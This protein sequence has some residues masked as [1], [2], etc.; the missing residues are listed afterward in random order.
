MTLNSDDSSTYPNT[1]YSFNLAAAAAL[2][3]NDTTMYLRRERGEVYSTTE[4]DDA[5]IMAYER[6]GVIQVKG[7]VDAATIEA[8]HDAIALRR[9]A[10]VLER[11][12]TAKKKSLGMDQKGNQPDSHFNLM[13][14]NGGWMDRCHLCWNHYSELKQCSPGTCSGTTLASWIS[15]EAL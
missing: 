7:L 13:G 15:Q 2:E 10:A 14:K 11:V 4:I 5:A 3:K 6:D 9:T 1:E 8:I 12:V